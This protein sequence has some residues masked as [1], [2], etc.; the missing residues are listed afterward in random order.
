MQYKRGVEIEFEKSLG[1]NF[2]FCGCGTGGKLSRWATIPEQ[3][4][5]RIGCCMDAEGGKRRKSN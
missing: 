2:M 3:G 4:A 1:A 5:L